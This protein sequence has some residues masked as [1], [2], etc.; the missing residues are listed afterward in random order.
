V[1]RFCKI[2]PRQASIERIDVTEEEPEGLN[3]FEIR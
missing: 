1:V 3:G 2:G